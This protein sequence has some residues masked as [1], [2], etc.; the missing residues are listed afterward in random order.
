GRWHFWTL[1]R[2]IRVRSII[3]TAHDRPGVGLLR[4]FS[5]SETGSSP[6]TH[7]PLPSLG[8]VAFSADGDG[9]RG[10]FEPV[11]VGQM[12][13]TAAE[14]TLSPSPSGKKAAAVFQRRPPHILFIDLH[15][16]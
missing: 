6:N 5:F 14:D 13:A 16:V 7:P 3:D 8:A 15:I 2:H 11:T 9:G 1:H 4:F 12:V 10:H